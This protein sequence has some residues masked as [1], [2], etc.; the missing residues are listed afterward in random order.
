MPTRSRCHDSRHGMPQQRPLNNSGGWKWNGHPAASGKVRY[1]LQ[2]AVWLRIIVLNSTWCA[3]VFH[4]SIPVSAS[5]SAGGSAGAAGGESSDDDDDAAGEEEGA[6][7]AVQSPR[8]SA[9]SPAGGLAGSLDHLGAADFEAGATAAPTSAAAAGEV[10]SGSN[11]ISLLCN[12]TEDDASPLAALAQAASNVLSTTTAAAAA[13]TSSAAPSSRSRAPAAPTPSA[14]PLAGLLTDGSRFLQRRGGLFRKVQLYSGNNADGLAL[15]S[16]HIVGAAALFIMAGGLNTAPSIRLS[17]T[18]VLDSTV[19]LSKSL[20]DAETSAVAISLATAAAVTKLSTSTSVAA[21]LA[22]S[23][24]PAA[25]PAILGAFPTA[26]AGFEAR[27]GGATIATR[28]VIL[29]SVRASSAAAPL[30]PPS[31]ESLLQA[32]LDSLDIERMVIHPVNLFVVG[33]PLEACVLLPSTIQLH[34]CGVRYPYQL[35]GVTWAVGAVGEQHVA[36]L[37]PEGSSHQ[38]V[39][40]STANGEVSRAASHVWDVGAVA[41]AATDKPF[42]PAVTAILYC[43]HADPS[44]VPVGGGEVLSAQGGRGARRTSA[45]S[46]LR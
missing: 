44:F 29:D 6:R 31:L 24:F 16:H 38:W 15:P 22:T 41:A 37:A 32:H 39:H 20:F 42:Q 30:V 40:S 7:G 34:V 1:I 19:I 8:S 46:S 2:Y 21:A 27:C 3:C 10:P 12:I 5:H 36:F 23:S 28:C 13:A 26:W 4:Y 17:N 43:L 33:A 9:S 14:P 45:T 18:S 11:D 25:L 35:A